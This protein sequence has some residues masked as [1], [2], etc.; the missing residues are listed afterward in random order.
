MERL[1]SGR[2]CRRGERGAAMVETLLSL[3][4]LLLI[5]FGMLQVFYFFAGQFFTDY[6]ALRGSRSRAVG[7]ADYLAQREAR[8]NAIGG[9]GLLVSPQLRS[10]QSA[11]LGK[12]DAG[13]FTQEK[14]LIER[15]MVGTTWVEYEYW[16]GK[17]A[18]EGR[19]VDTNFRVRISNSS[20]SAKVETEFTNYAFP[21]S[22]TRRLFFGSGLNLKGT[23]SLGNH[24]AVY[25]EN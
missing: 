5:L 7:F 18:L 22:L 15:Y 2:H 10:L 16:Y 17:P 11:G 13:Q 1:K 23:A 3:F 9:S 21:E 6:A 14:T 25:L 4:I 19:K 20:T 12:Y 24:S 8:V